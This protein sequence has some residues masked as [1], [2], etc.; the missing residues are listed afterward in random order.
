MAAPLPPGFVLDLPATHPATGRPVLKNN[1]GSFSTEESVTLTHPMLNGGR[2]TNVPS[3]WNGQRPPMVMDDPGFEDYVAEQAIKS[4]Q[5]FPAFE[6]IEQ[7]VAA[8]KQRSS[9][10]GKLSPALAPPLPPGFVLDQAPQQTARSLLAEGQGLPP[11]QDVAAFEQSARTS[12]QE[13][14]QALGQWAKETATVP[15]KQ[16]AQDL[17]IPGVEIT[18]EEDAA[19]KRNMG[20]LTAAGVG[21]LA[22]RWI[23]GQTAG[24]LKFLGRGAQSWPKADRFLVDSAHHIARQGAAAAGGKATVGDLL[25]PTITGAAVGTLVDAADPSRITGTQSEFIDNPVAAG[26]GVLTAA[27]V[28]RDTLEDLMIQNPRWRALMMSAGGSHPVATSIG[29]TLGYLAM[30]LGEVGAEKVDDVVKFFTEEDA[31]SETSAAPPARGEVMQGPIGEP[32]VP[33]APQAAVPT[34]RQYAGASDFTGPLPSSKQVPPPDAQQ[35]LARLL[36][37]G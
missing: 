30:K 15:A 2:P 34:G 25:S 29:A 35:L 13:G 20:E 37:T 3:I 19:F 18:S 11:Q 14:V 33:V 16:I 23:A 36:M 28:A 22:G 32:A 12:G 6:T 21:G 24:M 10:L 31:P 9:E 8:A 5:S 27:R 7:A 26:A 17:H 4:G 1:D